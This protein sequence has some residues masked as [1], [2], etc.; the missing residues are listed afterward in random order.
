VTDWIRRN[1]DGIGPTQYP[2]GPHLAAVQEPYLGKVLLCI[3][4]SGSMYAQE[5]GGRRFELAAAG[6]RRFVAEAI[7]ANYQVGLILWNHDV[8][9]NV[10]LSRDP[11]QLLVVLDQTRP[12]GCTDI[13]PALRLGTEQL[14]GLTGDRVLAIFG[15]GDIGPVDV[16]LA[17]ARDA[18]ARGIRIVVRGLGTHA[19]TQLSRIATDADDDPLIPASD[20]IEAGL[21]SMARYLTIRRKKR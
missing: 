13:T 16:A 11:E 3:D 5:K 18:K 9:C 19:A 4:I 1:Y 8:H 12:C 21:A 17:A 14:G 20:A 15:D 6:A 10:T 7:E 2:A